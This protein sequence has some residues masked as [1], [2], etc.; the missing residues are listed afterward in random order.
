[1]VDGVHGYVDHV[2][3]HVVVEQGGVLEHAVILDL[4]VEEAIVL[5]QVWLHIHALLTI[6]VRSSLT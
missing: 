6:L 4:T 3:R 1:M 2:V 5:A